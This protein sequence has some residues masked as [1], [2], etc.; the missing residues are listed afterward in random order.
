MGTPKRVSRDDLLPG[1][2]TLLAL[3]VATVISC[4]FLFPFAIQLGFDEG[5][6]AAGVERMIDGRSLPYV[7]AVSIR[8]PFLYW[9]Q[10]ILQLLTG[11]FQFTGSRVLSLLSGATTLLAGFC[12]AWAAG[13]P[14]A[15][16]VA[17]AVNVL[18]L[19][20]LYDPGAGI[21]ITA[22]PVAI[23]YISTAFALVSYALYRART[24]R[25]RVILLALG[26][27]A[28][29]TGGLTKQTL[30]VCYLP[31][32][33]WIA[34]HGT[35]EVGDSTGARIRRWRPLLRGWV[36]PFLAGGVGL[37]MLVLVRYAFAREFGTFIYWSSGVSS[38]IYMSPYKGRVA[39][40]VADWFQGEP[41]ALLGAGLALTVALGPAI[42]G[43]TRLSAGAILE[44]FGRAAFETAVGLMALTLLLA[45]A[46]PLRM[47]PHYFL[48]VWIFFGL[49]V[50]L[51]IERFAV[52]GAASPRAAQ[53]VV[54]LICGALLVSSGIH[55]FVD[56][57]RQR[58]AG[59][60]ANPRPNPVCAELDRI[61]GAGREE[62]FIWGTAGDLYITCQRRC[63]SRYT[64][65]TLVVG[66]VPPQWNEPRADRVPAGSQEKLLAELS[67]RPPKAIIDHAISI[68]GTS[69]ADVPAYARFL[70]DN[71]CR[72]QVMN[73]RGKTLTIYGRKDLPACQ[74]RS[75]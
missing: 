68:P 39:Q 35:L 18:V 29:A 25:R 17:A 36:L 54:V 10:E 49:T 44:G 63:P 75:P 47:W 2:L 30:A 1:L 60:W 62:V 5:Y 20:T 19:S 13:W 52:R 14:L 48:P 28:L 4:F 12:A 33:G 72:L 55:R 61:V 70:D 6:E 71:Y 41:W 65:T 26:G 8:G 23:A 9:S 46:V 21:A 34:L 15:G 31:V 66:I 3:L 40:L 67:S 50:G 69:F 42:G 43:V 51:L 37:V 24:S 59:S 11:R 45:G 16:A 32:L 53:A 56:L 22:E 58:A 73:D 64:H 74:E 27:A 57:R 38:R 7:D